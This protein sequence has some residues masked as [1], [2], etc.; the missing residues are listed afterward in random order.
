MR[1]YA[2]TAPMAGL[3]ESHAAGLVPVD[4]FRPPEATSRIVRRVNREERCAA[5]IDEGI[6]RG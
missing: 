2:A 5:K 3:A 4:P 6:P 1:E